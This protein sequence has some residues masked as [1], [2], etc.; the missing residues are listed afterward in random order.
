MSAALY[1]LAIILVVGSLLVL[2]MAGASLIV[3]LRRRGTHDQP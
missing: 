3:W 1:V 2:G